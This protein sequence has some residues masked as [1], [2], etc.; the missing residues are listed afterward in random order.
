MATYIERS[1]PPSAAAIS[2]SRNR[3]RRRTDVSSSVHCPVMG[4]TVPKTDAPCAILSGLCY[5]TCDSVSSVTRQ[6]GKTRS[7][8]ISVTPNVQRTVPGRSRSDSSNV[9]YSPDS[10]PFFFTKVANRVGLGRGSLRSLNIRSTAAVRRYPPQCGHRYSVASPPIDI[11]DGVP[12]TG[13]CCVVNAKSLQ[14]SG[15]RASELN[16]H[17]ELTDSR[18][19][20]TLTIEP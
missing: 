7:E 2:R 10:S 17:H 13:Q 15:G 19:T 3:L 5:L 8:V 6:A 1:V 18:I 12:H 4:K 9:G 11:C 16:A 20:R 14:L